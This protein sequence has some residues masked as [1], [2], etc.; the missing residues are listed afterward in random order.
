MDISAFIHSGIIEKFCA[1]SCT[2]EEVAVVENLANQY[3]EIRKEIQSMNLSFENYL[4]SNAI[5]P[6]PKVKS[7]VMQSVY[8]QHAQEDPS[9]PP[10]VHETTPETIASWMNRHSFTYPAE[11]FE[12]LYMIGLP[13]TGEVT[14]FIV[15]AKE[16]HEEEM[17]EDFV[18][19][20]YVAKG[21][22]TMY[23]NQAVVDYKEGDIITIR[24]HVPHRA[25]VTSIE[26]MFALVQ[27]QLC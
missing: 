17:H 5:K 13:S 21:S 27:R 23:Y 6:S 8:R 22:C 24:P 4:L 25:V 15:F 16:G 9:Y 19:Y 1:G 20:L 18:E 11:G 3:P 2:P 14:N 7:T 12:N 26:P 10:L